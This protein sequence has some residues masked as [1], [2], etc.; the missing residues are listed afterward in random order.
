MNP[1]TSRLR[2]Q[3]L[4]LLSL[5]M[6]FLVLMVLMTLGLGFRIRQKHELQNLADASAYSN[7]VMTARA[8]N[9]IAT[10]NRL[11]VSHYVSMLAAE[12]LISFAGLARGVV[13]SVESAEKKMQSDSCYSRLSKG[14]KDKLKDLVKAASQYESDTALEWSNMDAAAG[15]ATQG[16]QGAIAGLRHQVVVGPQG[17]AVHPEEQL[18][19]GD[20]TSVRLEKN[21]NA[22]ALPKAILAAAGLNDV[23]ILGASANG[24]SPSARLSL[25][26]AFCDYGSTPT[27]THNELLD[28]GHAFTGDEP[29]QFGLCSRPSFNRNQLEA[30]MGSRGDAFVRNGTSGPDQLFK[31]LHQRAGSNDVQMQMGE[32]LGHAHFGSSSLHRGTLSTELLLAEHHGELQLQ[33]GGCR[34]SVPI[35]SHVV[36]THSGDGHDEHVWTRGTEPDS[37]SEVDHTMGSCG[38][39]CPSVWVR[40][41]GFYGTLDAA[42]LYGQPRSV[43]ALERNTQLNPMPWELHFGFQFRPQGPASGFD[44]RGRTAGGNNISMMRAL[45]TALVYY[46]KD[47]DF[48]EFPNLLNPFWRATLVGADIDNDLTSVKT[49]FS[50]DFQAATVDE[51][52]SAAFKG[53]H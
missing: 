38:G 40:S 42:N 3:N 8:Y 28:D 17:G 33:I 32:Q 13:N 19:P 48:K 46:H 22:D 16:I 43:V 52:S 39:L 18:N 24:P 36:S 9:D 5:T 35:D 21:L 27:Q 15:R 14:Q 51:F 50:N 1:F 49:V 20:P 10:V 7:A 41:M 2:G 6:L 30:A 47:Q 29:A 37:S 12:S 34:V 11:Q 53:W 25:K 4:V 44:G 45:A 31:D 23:S 26:E